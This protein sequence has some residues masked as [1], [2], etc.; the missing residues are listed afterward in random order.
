MK[1]TFKPLI[2]ILVFISITTSSCY[3]TP[4]AGN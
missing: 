4:A 1:I 3:K 2:T